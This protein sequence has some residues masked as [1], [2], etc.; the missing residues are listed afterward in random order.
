MWV[1]V[2]G[3]SVQNFTNDFG[4]MTM[5]RGIA[6]RAGPALTDKSSVWCVCV[7]VRACVC[8]CVSLSLSSSIP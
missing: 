4:L 7:C 5:F 1:G 8:A 6:A 3:V 2:G